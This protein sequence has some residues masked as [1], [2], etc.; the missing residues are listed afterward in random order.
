MNPVAYNA[1]ACPYFIDAD[2][3]TLPLELLDYAA[4]VLPALMVRLDDEDNAD[5]RNA[6]IVFNMARTELH[7]LQEQAKVEGQP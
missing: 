1:L 5:L 6:L 7:R 3:L 2:R 4:L